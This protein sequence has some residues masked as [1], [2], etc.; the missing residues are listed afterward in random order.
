MR[1]RLFE[2]PK[3]YP[4]NA[5]IVDSIFG[6]TML[7]IYDDWQ[8]IPNTYKWDDELMKGDK[9]KF[10]KSWDECDEVYFH[11]S[12]NNHWILCEAS[13]KEW[14]IS[15]YDLDHSNINQNVLAHN[16]NQ[17]RKMLPSL[18][19]C[20]GMLD[21]NPHLKLQRLKH[22]VAEF[23]WRRIST[24]VVPQSKSCGDCSVFAIKNLEFLLGDIPL[25]YAV[26]DH[27]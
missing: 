2:L 10:K 26:D 12:I 22:T 21:K 5:T 20:S 3:T 11:M 27:I 9:K 17:R 8:K 23:D 18:L 16:M 15:I 13:F 1:R 7:A 19:K 4:V 24:N 14:M 25:S 6:Q